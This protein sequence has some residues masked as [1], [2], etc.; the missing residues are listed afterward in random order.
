MPLYQSESS[1]PLN[2]DRILS[3]RARPTKSH[4]SPLPRWVISEYG[5]YCDSTPTTSMRE[6]IMFDSTKSM[7][8]Y[9]PQNG[10]ALFGRCA[11][12][13]DSSSTRPPASTIP[14]ICFFIASMLAAGRR[15]CQ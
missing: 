1:I 5:R 3:S 14:T 7:M 2:G 15:R 10:T 8:R 12:S 9:I 13:T 11:V 4:G 6:R